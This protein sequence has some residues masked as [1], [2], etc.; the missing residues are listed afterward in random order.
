VSAEGWRRSHSLLAKSPVG[1]VILGQEVIEHRNVKSR[2]LGKYA[3]LLTLLDFD[4]CLALPLPIE[5]RPL[6]HALFLFWGPGR[7]YRSEA[8]Q[9]AQLAA[10]RLGVA[11]ERAGW[12]TKVI[13]SQR[14]SL[15]GKLSV[16][17][18]HETSGKL[19]G[20]EIRLA[21]LHAAAQS[22]AAN[23]Q[24]AG[25]D[26]VAHLQSEVA[27]LRA[28]MAELLGRVG[29]FQSLMQSTEPNLIDVN[30]V[31]RRTVHNLQSLALNRYKVALRAELGTGLPQCLGEAAK[32]DHACQNLI[33]NALQWVHRKPATGGTVVVRTG[34]AGD[35]RHLWIRV[36][37]D[38]YGI[39]QR[40]LPRLFEFGFTTR[41][42]EGTGLGLY[43]T[44]LFVEQMGG[45]VSV[46]ESLILIGTPFRIDLP[47]VKGR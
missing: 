42:N 34:L 31:V 11:L 18:A 41:K 19:S 23:W 33:L 38:G 10:A 45:S 4:S 17:M 24:T 47:V 16:V 39:H 5:E 6:E 35:R 32:L 2:W 46:E 3:N 8:M 27:T 36:H 25:P 7:S 1:D 22:L 14:L 28:D 20:M 44:R 29:E 26:R 21:N 30:T 12:E 40:L 37:D 9:Q 15:A 43:V 13:Q